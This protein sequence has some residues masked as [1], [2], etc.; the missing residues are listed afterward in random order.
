MLGITKVSSLRSFLHN[1]TCIIMCFTDLIDYHFQNGRSYGSLYIL[2]PASYFAMH[3]SI[4]VYKH[5]LLTALVSVSPLSKVSLDNRYVSTYSKHSLMS[6]YSYDV[7]KIS[8]DFWSSHKSCSSLSL[9]MFCY[10]RCD[11]ACS[12]VGPL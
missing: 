2:L 11:A 7:G 4:H 3:S 10:E 8:I 5:K 12:S 6:G 1:V 9:L